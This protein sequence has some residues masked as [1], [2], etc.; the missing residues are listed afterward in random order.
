MQEVLAE[1]D[2]SPP[3][4]AALRRAAFRLLLFGCRQSGAAFIK[5]GQ[6]ASSRPDLLPE[7]TMILCGSLSNASLLDFGA[8]L[9]LL[10]C[11]P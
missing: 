10:H 9:F 5:W 8:G 7:V 6:W 2:N 3:G 1:G 4:G 11:A